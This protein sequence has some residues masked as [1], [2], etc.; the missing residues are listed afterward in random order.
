MA[1]GM[2]LS[3]NLSDIRLSHKMLGD[4]RVLIL[5][6]H[7]FWALMQ[8][9]R[10]CAAGLVWTYSEPSDGSLPDDDFR[11]MR[12]ACLGSLRRWRKVR[13]EIECFFKIKAGRWHLNEPWI[14][15]GGGGRLA[16]PLSIRDEISKREGERC[17]YCG[18][19]DHPLEYDHIFPVARGGT[20]DPSNL[21][22]ACDSCNRSKAA[23][24]LEEWLN[25]RTS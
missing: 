18:A 10:F 14:E 23:K 12:L 9:V 13:P 7:A 8:L 6:Y 19:T 25:G 15:V 4:Q 3:P 2:R 17:T 1:V 20:N 24:T 5:S 16:I 22:L 11:L 21:T